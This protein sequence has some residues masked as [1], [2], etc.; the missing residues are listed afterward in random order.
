MRI[1]MRIQIVCMHFRS[2]HNIGKDVTLTR[3]Y[4]VNLPL[5]VP[6][7]GIDFH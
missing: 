4:I 5:H 7:K 2:Q 1:V 6:N 3:A